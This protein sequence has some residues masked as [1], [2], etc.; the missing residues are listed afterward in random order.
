M[1]LIDINRKFG[2]KAEH[3]NPMEHYKPLKPV[4]EIVYGK[5]KNKKESG[6]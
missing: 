3:E 5:C 2:T 6:K 4:K 1:N